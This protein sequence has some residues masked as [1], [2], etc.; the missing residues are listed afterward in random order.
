MSA[1][2]KGQDLEDPE[3]EKV[4]QVAQIAT[5]MPVNKAAL[6]YISER[7][8]KRDQLSDIPFHRLW[9]PADAGQLR[10]V[11]LRESAQQSLLL[12]SNGNETLVLPITQ[13]QRKHL[14][15]QQRGITVRISQ[16]T[17]IHVQ[18]QT[19]ER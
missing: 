10:F 8:S 17:A 4:R 16:T 1:R 9:Q 14:A 12:L 13:Q 15:Q 19:Q 18:A 5:P 2:G 3:L 11:G 7:N 6:D